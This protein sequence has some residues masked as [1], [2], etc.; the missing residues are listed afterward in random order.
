MFRIKVN[1]SFSAA[2]S[3]LNY[4][5]KCESLHG[6]NWKVKITVLGESLDSSGMIMDFGEL[7]HLL[8]GVLDIFDHCH[9]NKL[10][11]FIKHSPSSEE[12]AR[13]IFINLKELILKKEC[14]LEEVI[15][16]ETDTSCASYRE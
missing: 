8:N 5:G 14:T 11:Y 1:S 3:L 16:W 2:H 7:K 15:V 4:K 12:I 9:L 6:H 13:Y 10:E